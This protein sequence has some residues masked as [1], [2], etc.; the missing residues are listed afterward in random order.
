MSDF[1]IPDR[2][3]ARI[4]SMVAAFR[5]QL[6]ATYALAY[7]QGAID[8]TK[9]LTEK[10]APAEPQARPSYRAPEDEVQ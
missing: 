6:E 1:T 9:S 4:D 3:K 2:D 5:A 7:I 8:S 10:M